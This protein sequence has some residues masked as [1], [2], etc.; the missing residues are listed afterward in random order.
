MRY[1]LLYNLQIEDPLWVSDA[2]QPAD[3]LRATRLEATTSYAWFCNQ[4]LQSVVPAAGCLVAGLLGVLH[5]SS[6]GVYHWI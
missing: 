2:H 5:C 4:V 6:T 3:E 1:Q